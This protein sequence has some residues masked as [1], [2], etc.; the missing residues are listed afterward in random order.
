MFRRLFVFTAS[1]EYLDNRNPS[2]AT[3]L[4]LVGGSNSN[5]ELNHKRCTSYAGKERPSIAIRNM[6]INANSFLQFTSFGDASSNLHHSFR[7][8]LLKRH[9]RNPV[10]FVSNM[11]L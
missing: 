8:K 2:F 7:Y 6:R 9:T 4:R 3:Q 11:P 1:I 5:V 10:C